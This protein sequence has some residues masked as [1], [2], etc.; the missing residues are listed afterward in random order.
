M[1]LLTIDILKRIAPRPSNPEK[2]KTW[3]AYATTLAGSDA[4]GLLARLEI[5]ENPI[6]LAMLLA[7]MLHETGGLTIIRENLNYSA[8]RLKEVWP[9]W[10][11]DDALAKRYEHKPRELANYIYGKETTIGRNL[12]NTVDPDDGWNYRGGG[13]MQTTGRAGYREFGKYNGVD[14]EQRPGLIEV[15]INSLSAGCGEWAS[16]K[17]NSY[18]DAGNFKACCNGINRGNPKSSGVPIGWKERRAWLARCSSAL[19]IALPESF[20]LSTEEE[21][22]IDF[23]GVSSDDYPHGRDTEVPIEPVSLL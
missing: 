11:S 19:G 17:L 4:S 3:D 15:P 9:H 6:R 20:E 7:N 1:S 12:G 10:F 8:Q 21:E 13:L 16:L 22:R 5:S 14:L 23:D 2:A 18:A